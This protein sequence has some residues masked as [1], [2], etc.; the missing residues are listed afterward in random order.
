MSA[1]VIFQLKIKRRKAHIAIL[2]ENFNIE[3]EN[4]QR[5]EYLVSYLMQPERVTKYTYHYNKAYK[6]ASRMFEVVQKRKGAQPIEYDIQNMTLH[7]KQDLK[8]IPGLE[9]KDNFIY[10]AQA[11]QKQEQE[12]TKEQTEK[13]IYKEIQKKEELQRAFER[14]WNRLMAAANED[15]ERALAKNKK[16]KK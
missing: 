5:Y 2:V 14:D 7:K 3:I 9:I 12:Q 16:V 8:N 15:M 4:I 1:I 13:Q 10:R 11:E 6:N